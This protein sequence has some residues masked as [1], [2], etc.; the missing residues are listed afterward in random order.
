MNER[1]WEY[2]IHT[3]KKIYGTDHLKQG[4]KDILKSVTPDV[5]IQLWQELKY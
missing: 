3:V 1:E 4:I 2:D 5:V